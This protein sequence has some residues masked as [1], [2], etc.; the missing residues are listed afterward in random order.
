MLD[1]FNAFIN[2][3]QLNKS[4]CRL[5]EYVQ[6]EKMKSLLFNNTH[7]FNIFRNHNNLAW[8]LIHILEIA[9]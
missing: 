7:N 4:P 8:N 6:K 9:R 5:S 2:K 3:I 1:N